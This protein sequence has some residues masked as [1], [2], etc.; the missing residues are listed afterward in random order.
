[1][2]IFKDFKKEGE[3]SE[4][5][6]EKYEDRLP[7]Q[8]IEVWKNYGFGSFLNGFLK[9]INPDDFQDILNESY[10]RSDVSIPVFSTA[11]ADLITWEEGNYLSLVKYRRGDF[12]IFLS[13]FKFFFPNLKDKEFCDEVLDWEQYLEA[14]KNKEIPK[15]EECYGYTPILG[16]GGSEKIENLET[17]KLKEHIMLIN[18]LMGRIE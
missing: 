13:K 10:F 1:M 6:I 9:I 11:M 7:E 12:K 8:L 18:E 4:E 2:E 14:I 15:Y 3:V 5:L 16:L 17:V